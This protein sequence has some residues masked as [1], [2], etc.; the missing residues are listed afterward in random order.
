MRFRSTGLGKVEL[1]GR[2]SDLSPAGKDLL[3]FDIKTYEP[4]EWHLRAGIERKD[5]PKVVKAMLKPSILF[6]I[7]RT[8]FYL[9]R[10]PKELED[11]MAEI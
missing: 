5:I 6:H 11:I 8:I 1:K 2:M 4:V 10:S 7:I 9:K 3:V